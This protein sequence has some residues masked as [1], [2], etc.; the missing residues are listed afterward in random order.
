MQGVELAW[1]AWRQWGLQALVMLSFTLQITLLILAEFRKHVDSRVLRF[2]VWSAYMLADATA[3]YVLG[4]MSVTSSTS[5][6]HE[7]MA[8]WAPFLLLHLGGQDNIT[9]YA[10]EDNQLWLRHLQTLAVQ[11][12]SAGY[13]LFESPIIGSRSLLRPATIILILS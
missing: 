5:G 10:V 4:H 6:E 7:L 1:N 9:A 3:I 12:F 2:F 8:L 11:V 13:V